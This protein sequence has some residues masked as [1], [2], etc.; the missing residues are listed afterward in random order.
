MI[1]I[2]AQHVQQLPHEIYHTFV[3]DH[4]ESGSLK[5]AVLRVNQSTFDGIK[6]SGFERTSVRPKI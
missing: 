2:Q 3:D 6:P 4:D 5:H 1:L